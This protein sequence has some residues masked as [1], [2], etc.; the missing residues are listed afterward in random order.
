MEK[1]V[2]IYAGRVLKFKGAGG[3]GADRFALDAAVELAYALGK[4]GGDY[5]FRDRVRTGTRPL[6]LQPGD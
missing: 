2:F 4:A 3:A 1:H 5:A 6:G